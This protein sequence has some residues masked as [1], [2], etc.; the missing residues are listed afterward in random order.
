MIVSSRIAL[1][2]NWLHILGHGVWYVLRKGIQ[3]G[4]EGDRDVEREA[5]WCT[6]VRYMKCSHLSLVRFQIPADQNV[7]L[8]LYT[9]WADWKNM[10][11]QSPDSVCP[12]SPS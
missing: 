6:A 5:D 3:G 7:A 4:R 2:D 10:D 1:L 8:I 12:A 9:L 11:D